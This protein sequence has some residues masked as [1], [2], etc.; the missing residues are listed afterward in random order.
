[1]YQW[2]TAIVRF[3][4]Y[5]WTNHGRDL[6]EDGLAAFECD[7]ALDSGLYIWSNPDKFVLLMKDVF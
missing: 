3:Q 6:N 4:D 1:M 7:M 2:K 5:G